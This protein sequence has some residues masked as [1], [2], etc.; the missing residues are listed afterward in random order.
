MELRA[1]RE[2]RGVRVTRVVGG[3]VTLAGLAT[4]ACRDRQLGRALLYLPL[5]REVRELRCGAVCRRRE[6]VR[7]GSADPRGGC[8]RTA[9]VR[10]A[11]LVSYRSWRARDRAAEAAVPSAGGADDGRRGLSS[12][13]LD[14]TEQADNR[15]YGPGGRRHRVLDAPVSLLRASLELLRT[16]RELPCGA[17]RGIPDQRRS[18]SRVSGTQGCPRGRHGHSLR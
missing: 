11:G 15:P 6:A 18:R 16:G 2:Q 17:L 10:A 9:G 14:G 13:V 3:T 5:L 7:P 12:R 4:V 8:G 1:G